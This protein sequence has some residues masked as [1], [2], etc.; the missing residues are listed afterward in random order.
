MASCQASRGEPYLH[1]RGK[2][3]PGRYRALPCDEISTIIEAFITSSSRGIVP[4]A[5]IEHH[6]I[7]SAGTIMQK[8][9]EMYDRQLYSLAEPIV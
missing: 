2:R 9:M 6:D 4:I 8:L 1:W 5:Q 3:R 7:G